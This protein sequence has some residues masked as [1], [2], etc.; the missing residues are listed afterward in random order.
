MQHDIGGKYLEVIDITDRPLSYWEYS[1]HSLLVILAQKIPLP[2]ITTDELRRGVE[3][4]ENE[5]YLTWGY[6]EKWSA[7]MTIILLE[8][9]VITQDEIDYELLGESK[10][11]IETINPLFNIGDIVQVKSEDTRTRWRKPHLRCPGY[12]FNCKGVIENYIGKININQ[13]EIYFEFIFNLFY[14]Y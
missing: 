4:L 13:R 8:R 14:Y 11:A 6:Y 12:V 7:A 10:N 1:I 3:S 2:L 9:G 5:S